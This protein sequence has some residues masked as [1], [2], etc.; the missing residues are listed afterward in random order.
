MHTDENP[1]F[2][3]HFLYLYISSNDPTLIKKLITLMCA[4]KQST[5]PADVIKAFLF[6]RNGI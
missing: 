2:C 4:W 5:L 6:K 3:M 1:L